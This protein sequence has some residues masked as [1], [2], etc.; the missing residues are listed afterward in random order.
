MENFCFDYFGEFSE[1]S[2]LYLTGSEAIDK[3]I[4]ERYA[5]EEARFIFTTEGEDLVLSIE[6]HSFCMIKKDISVIKLSYNDSQIIISYQ[7]EDYCFSY[8]D[9]ITPELLSFFYNL[10]VK[11]DFPE[12]LYSRYIEMQDK[13]LYKLIDSYQQ[14]LP[15]NEFLL[16]YD[17]MD[18]TTY[19]D[20]VESFATDALGEAPLLYIQYFDN[21]TKP[22]GLL[23][24][25]KNI[26][27]PGKS[28]SL[29]GVNSIGFSEHIGI[30]D[31]SIHFY[32]NEKLFC[33]MPVIIK[34][35]PLISYHSLSQRE[36]FSDNVFKLME[37][38]S[39]HVRGKAI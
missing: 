38:I 17:Q 23:V 14:T 18:E 19:S 26:Y 33:I 25:S 10:D 7:S 9:R 32:I 21:A 3:M 28:H 16:F 34:D 31:D 12:F 1:L 36:F 15:E 6:E 4:E 20:I 13:A 35:K 30:T 5:G 11:L 29:R 39:D 24:T 37:E 22:S 27:T 8:E 2:L